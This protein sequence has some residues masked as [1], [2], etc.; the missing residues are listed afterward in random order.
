MVN[1]RGLS[2]LDPPADR[3]HEDLPSA[4]IGGRKQHLHLSLIAYTPACYAGVRLPL[5]FNYKGVEDTY[6]R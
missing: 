1:L 3:H 5:Y 6:R 2:P 4:D